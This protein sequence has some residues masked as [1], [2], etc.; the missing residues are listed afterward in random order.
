MRCKV[1]RREEGGGK[2]QARA[3]SRANR[4]TDL[5]PQHLAL[6]RMIQFSVVSFSVSGR[7]APPPP[8]RLG[9]HRFPGGSELRCSRFSRRYRPFP[10][11]FPSPFSL[12]RSRLHVENR[13][14]RMAETSHVCRVE[15]CEVAETTRDDARPSRR[16]RTSGCWS[17][18][19]ITT[20]TIISSSSR[21]RY[22][23]CA[24]A[25]RDDRGDARSS[26]VATRTVLWIFDIGSLDQAFPSFHLADP[27]STR[28]RVERK[29]LDNLTLTFAREMRSSHFNFQQN[30]L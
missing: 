13:R 21:S 27:W 29:S 12:L 18:T 10:G 30:T 11:R 9:S 8:L 22:R 7:F 28:I 3:R 4:P 23:R 15:D 2:S 24:E 19:T 17:S 25:M 26:R 14:S 20:I 6:S 1:G 16:T 5:E